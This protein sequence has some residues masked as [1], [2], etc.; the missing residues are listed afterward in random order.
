MF[1]YVCA[2]AVLVFVRFVEVNNELRIRFGERLPLER[3]LFILLYFIFVNF[4]LTVDN[5]LCQL[6]E[7]NV[8]VSIPSCRRSPSEFL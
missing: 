2:A 6:S 1:S 5:L 3:P 8:C 4:F 7:R